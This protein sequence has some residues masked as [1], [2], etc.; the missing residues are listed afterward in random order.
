MIKSI[1]LRTWLYMMGIV[2]VVLLIM[3]L[4]GVIFLQSLTSYI[5]NENNILLL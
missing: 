3:W 4:L 1:K 5:I 2:S